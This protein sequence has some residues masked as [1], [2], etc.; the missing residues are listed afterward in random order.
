MVAGLAV[1]AFVAYRVRALDLPGC[2]LSFVMGVVVY[3]AVGVGW[4]FLLVLFAGGGS[5]VSR[6]GARHKMRVAGEAEATPR[7]WRNVVGNGGAAVGVACLGF[8]LPGEDLALAFSVAVSVAAADTFASEIGCFAKRPV[9]IT[10]PSR[11]VPPGT[12]G[13]VSWLGTISG[14]LAAAVV[15]GTAVVVLPLEA[16]MVVWIV[17]AG[18]MGSLLDSLLGALWERSVH[19]PHGSL[20]KTH[21]NL[22]ATSVP[23]L[24]ALAATLFA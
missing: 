12:D 11:T 22:L 23:A 16:V 1:L 7:G 6:L 17:V 13:G 10:R 18:A 20:S 19:N 3:F 15:G 8:F 9:L 4:V 24:V 14:V 21:V 5:L 2:V